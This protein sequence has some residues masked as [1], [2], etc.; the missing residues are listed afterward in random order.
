MFI[1][2]IDPGVTSGLCVID[3]A[4]R[5]VASQQIVGSEKLATVLLEIIV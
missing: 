4:N 1:I 3:T 5:T 2:S